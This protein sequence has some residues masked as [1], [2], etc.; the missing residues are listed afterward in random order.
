VT[1]LYRLT[2]HSM[3]SCCTTWRSYRNHRLL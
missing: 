3:T 2:S 1:N